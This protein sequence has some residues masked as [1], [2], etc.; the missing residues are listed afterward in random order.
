[1]KLDVWRTALY[2]EGCYVPLVSLTQ[3]LEAGCL[4][5]GITH[6]GCQKWFPLPLNPKVPIW[7]LDIDSL[8]S[9]PIFNT[10]P[11]PALSP[12]SCAIYG[13]SCHFH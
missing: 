9:L 6:V 4:K 2:L 7:N 3:T 1:M 5:G 11:L 8:D 10:A 12:F 13:N